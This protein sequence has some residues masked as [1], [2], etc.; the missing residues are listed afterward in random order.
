M[1]SFTEN[2][3]SC[4]RLTPAERQV[5]LLAADGLPYKIIARR[6]DKSPA[7]VRNQLHAV[8]QKLAVANRAALAGCL[9]Q[10]CS[11]SDIVSGAPV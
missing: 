5:A 3:P 9:H 2:N 10:C 8:Y 4:Q 7:T 11:A 1:S 6:L